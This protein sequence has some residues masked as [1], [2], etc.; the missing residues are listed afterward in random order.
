[1]PKVSPEHLDRRRAEILDA[2]RRCFARHGFEGA[3]VSRLEEEAGLSRGAIFHYYPSKED[4]LIA[5]AEVDA[6]R[7]AELWRR[8]GFA[9]ALRLLAAEDPGRLGATFEFG[10]RL[11]TNADFRARWER[12]GEPIDDAIYSTLTRDQ[13]A[14]VV[15][16]DLPLEKLARF[17][18][19]VLDGFASQRAV[20]LE[21]EAAVDALVTLVEDALRPTTPAGAPPRR[22][23]SLD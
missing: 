3:T 8:E 13:E 15:R 17:L 21:P 7:L 10:R 19:V 2:A 14:G 22:S 23:P 6:E 9:A 12:R 20:G 5:V 11:R 16:T 18:G 4:L 1:V